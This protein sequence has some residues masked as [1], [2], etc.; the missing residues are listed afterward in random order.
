MQTKELQTPGSTPL[1]ALTCSKD[2]ISRQAYDPH[3]TSIATS[4][5]AEASATEVMEKL[6]IGL[7][8]GYKTWFNLVILSFASISKGKII[9]I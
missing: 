1:G 5:L 2:S 7:L 8:P 6:G 4:A 9:F 3:K